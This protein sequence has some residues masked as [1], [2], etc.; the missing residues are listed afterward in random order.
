MT[1]PYQDLGRPEDIDG[2]YQGRVYQGMGF[3][4][5]LVTCLPFLITAPPQLALQS[6]S[7]VFAE[8][9]EPVLRRGEPMRL[10]WTLAAATETDC[11]QPSCRRCAICGQPSSCSWAALSASPWTRRTSRSSQC[12]RTRD[13]MTMIRAPEAGLLCSGSSP[14]LYMV[15]PDILHTATL[16]RHGKAARQE[17]YSIAETFTL[18]YCLVHRE[19]CF[20]PRALTQA[21][22]PHLLQV[23]RRCSC[24]SAPIHLQKACWS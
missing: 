24:R 6:A 12:P 17:P 18:L 2:V 21:L 20:G 4:Q 10:G 16:V 19:A 23:S 7:P 15:V 8:V 3:L 13:T 9:L 22:S 1:G 11:Q 5:R 14:V